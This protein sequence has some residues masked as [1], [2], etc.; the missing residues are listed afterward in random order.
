M[1]WILATGCAQWISVP[2]TMC[3]SLCRIQV[4][5]TLQA[6]HSQHPMRRPGERA[7]PTPQSQKR[8]SSSRLNVKDA[9][10]VDRQI[11]ILVVLTQPKDQADPCRIPIQFEPLLKAGLF[12]AL[13]PAHQHTWLLRRRTTVLL[14]IL[15][16]FF[17]CLYEG[18]LL[19]SRKALTSWQNTL[20]CVA[21]NMAVTA[22]STALRDMRQTAR[23]LTRK[24]PPR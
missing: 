24:S 16:E 14:H 18:I 13:L 21:S 7:Y 11:V 20:Y 23:M 17:R 10:K 19:A 8:Q 5:S 4:I 3:S 2:S 1:L 15:W 9:L 6:T 22:S 12:P